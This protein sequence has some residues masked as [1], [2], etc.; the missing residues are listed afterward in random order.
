MRFLTG[1]RAHLTKLM[2]KF[3]AMVVPGQKA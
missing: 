1:M 3:A 2:D